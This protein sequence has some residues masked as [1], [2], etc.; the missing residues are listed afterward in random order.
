MNIIRRI[1]SRSFFKKLKNNIIKINQIPEIYLT[2]DIC[3]YA[4]NSCIDDFVFIPEQFMTTTMCDKA[5]RYNYSY[6]KYVP[7]K[8][9]SA[10]IYN[11]V[12]TNQS[13][14]MDFIDIEEL[15][16]DLKRIYIDKCIKNRPKYLLHI[17]NNYLDENDW[18]QATISDKQL[19]NN[20][21]KQHKTTLFFYKLIDLKPDFIAIIPIEMLSQPLYDLAFSRKKELIKYFPDKYITKEMS[22]YV[23]LNLR[24][25]IKK[26]PNRFQDNYQ[27]VNNFNSF[28]DSFKKII[29]VDVFE[30]AKTNEI[31]S[32]GK[33]YKEY[34]NLD[35]LIKILLDCGNEYQV[36]T[37]NIFNNYCALN[38]ILG[39]TNNC[40]V[41][42]ETIETVNN[43]SSKLSKYML[44]FIKYIKSNNKNHNYSYSETK[45]KVIWNKEYEY[46]YSLEDD[47]DSINQAILEYSNR[48]AINLD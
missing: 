44:D 33:K 41:K 21:P 11:Q 28:K 22:E 31:N 29:K 2:K 37:D 26:I 43:L 45:T 1:K 30:I 48:I 25:Y 6:I 8:Y 47:L 3:L 19:L 12:M 17:D 20:L 35:F 14:F 5:V 15:P 40:D 46:T 4:F 13:N 7:K 10:Q 38:E 27:C 42:K 18:L 23:K 16:N 36:N 39:N 34:R 32:N 9:R 24:E